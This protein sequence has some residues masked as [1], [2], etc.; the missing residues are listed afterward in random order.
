MNRIFYPLLLCAMISIHAFAAEKDVTVYRW[1]DEKGVVHFDQHQPPTNEYQELK[2]KTKYSP[3]QKPITETNIIHEAKGE[4]LALSS[5]AAAK[6]NIAKSNLRTLTDFAKVQI[7]DS[8][9]N[10]RIL[11]DVERLQRLRKNEREIELFCQ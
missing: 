3:I 9:G 10:S 11:T 2:I 1:V 8:N 5:D 7:T 6:C 4:N